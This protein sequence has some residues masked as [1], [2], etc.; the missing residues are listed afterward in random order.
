MRIVV[1]GG[2][3]FLGRNLTHR[4]VGQGHDVTII[5]P[6][7]MTDEH[8]RLFESGPGRIRFF[9]LRTRDFR[10]NWYDAGFNQIYHLGANASPPVY[11]AD[12][13]E[14]LLAGSVG[15][16]AICSLAQSASRARVLLASTSEVYG[17]PAVSPQPESYRGNV[18]PIGPRSMYDEAKRYA[19][20]Y[21]AAQI[22]CGLDARIARIFN[23]FGPGMKIDDGRM[24]TEFIKACFWDEPMPVH[25]DGQQT[26]TLC[27]VD[28]LVDGLI[29]LMNSKLERSV[30]YPVNIGGVDE[31]SVLDVAQEVGLAWT[32]VTGL[33]A[34]PI[35][36]VGQPCSQDPKKRKPDLG[37][38]RQLFSYAPKVGWKDGIQRT[39]QHFHENSS[40]LG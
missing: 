40:N 24:V 9:N 8:D 5:D 20:A 38:A 4:L 3:G 10:H 19:E 25:G 26:R 16:H 29:G 17:D 27:Y 31:V 6:G 23:T 21:I 12:P 32:K 14:S 37:R 28:D 22:R 35:A 13:I 30:P 36:F 1:T 34:P 11:K 7:E 18:D 39:V 2:L 33:E 15:T